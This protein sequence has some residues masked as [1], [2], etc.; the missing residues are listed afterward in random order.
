VSSKP[1]LIAKT[2]DTVESI[3]QRHGDYDYWFG[4]HCGGV[5]TIVVQAHKAPKDLPSP[6]DL[7]GVI[8]TGSPHSVTEPEEWTNL[9]ADWIVNAVEEGLPILGVCYG[10]Q[11]IAHA[12]GGEVIRNPTQYEIGSIE[13]E[14][15]KAGQQD[16]L[17]GSLKP[18][19]THL[20]FNAV[21]GDVVSRLPK[22]AI[23]LASNEASVNQAFRFRSHVWAV[24]FHPEFSE[25]VMKLYLT[26]RADNVREDAK[27]RGIDPD[28]LVSEVQENIRD[29]PSG[30]KLIQE[31]VH[32][33]VET[34]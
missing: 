4:Q 15:T 33:I 3:R 28:A 9:L 23:R 8:I 21:H 19:A 2:G 18:D 11:I 7:A 1:L 27:R 29:T 12:F 34:E 30:P 6:K 5:E 10:H 20:S 16:K 14:L 25:D 17:L 26:A 31:F 32:M 24:Q 13:I 22:G